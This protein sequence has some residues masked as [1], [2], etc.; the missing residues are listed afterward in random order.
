MAD[1]TTTVA[2]CSRSFSAHGAL[3]RELLSRYDRVRFNDAGESLS[4]EDL[5][6]FLDGRQ[7][8]IIGTEPMTAAVIERL[9]E[10]RVVSKQ[11][12][13]I[14]NLDMEALRARGIRVSVRSGENRRS[15]AELVVAAAITML[16]DLHNLSHEMRHGAWKPRN[17]P[18]LTGKRFGIVGLGNT[19]REVAALLKPFGCEIRAVDPGD[20]AD[21]RGTHGVERTT[22]EDV[23]ARSDIV[24]LHVP[25]NPSTHRLIDRDRLALMRPGSYLINTSRG[26]VVDQAALKD[27]LASGRL[28]GAALDVFEEEPPTDADLLGL[29][30][31]FATPHI[32]GTAHE[33]VLAMGMAAIDGLETAS[34]IP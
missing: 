14:D 10:L 33:A 25:L 29:P 8:V 22:L 6:T 28:A 24:S 17:G 5:A 19:G 1:A 18:W 13:G 11:G 3:R 26:A 15:V 2:V 31:L 12:A 4:G 30:N 7:K 23:L 34:V 20:D 21:F 32:A 16:R 9:P 27:A